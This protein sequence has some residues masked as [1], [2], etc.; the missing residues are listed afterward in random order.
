MAHS[1][2]LHNIILCDL[3]LYSVIQWAVW[4]GDWQAQK[5]EKTQL[6]AK[7]KESPTFFLLNHN[8][9]YSVLI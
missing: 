9:C 3:I 7:S 8:H 4:T 5:A 1:V 2:T 6:R